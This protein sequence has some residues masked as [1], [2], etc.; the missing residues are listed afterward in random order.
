MVG[1]A[2]DGQVPKVGHLIAETKPAIGARMGIGMFPWI[3]FRDRCAY[4]LVYCLWLSF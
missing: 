3:S 2:L 4:P 1:D